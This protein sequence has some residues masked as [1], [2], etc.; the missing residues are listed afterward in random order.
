MS[1]AERSWI[2]IVAGLPRTGTSMMMRMLEAG[3]VPALTDG[4]READDDNPRGYYEFEPAKRTKHDQS[5]LDRAP[6]HVVKMVYRL[7]YDLPDDRQYRVIF[8]NRRLSEVHASQEKMLDRRGEATGLMSPDDFERLFSGEVTRVKRWLDERD[9]FRTL[10][11]D[12]NAIVAN[13]AETVHRAS[14]LLGGLDETA[15]EQVVETA[16]YR[17]RA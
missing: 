17:Q 1:P 9:H 8:M 12:Y 6:G 7:L 2:T 11:V 14:E 13:P 4:V 5:W 16:L 15:M 3:G 10:H